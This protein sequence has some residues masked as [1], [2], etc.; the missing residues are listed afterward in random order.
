M[1][2]ALKGA[3]H[4]VREAVHDFVEDGCPT[5][6][7]SLSYYTVLSLPP[8]LVLVLLILG[9]VMDPEDVR[10]ALEEQI[11]T[12]MG[13][14]GADEVRKVIRNAERPGAGRPLASLLGIGA[15][16]FGAT[17]AFAQ[18]QAALNRAWEVEPDPAQGGIRNFVRKRLLSFG[19]ILA[20]GF[21]LLV[22]L[23]LSAALSAVG[24]LVAGRMAG[25]SGT[26]LQLMNSV[27]SFLV[28]TLLFAAIYKILPDARIAWR[29][30]WVGAA[31]TTLLF[32]LGKYFLGLYLGR[33]SPGDAYGAAGSLAVL[34]VWI[35]YS[36]MILLFGAELT[37]RWAE[38]HGTAIVPEKGAVRVVEVKRRVRE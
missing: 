27:V 3:F 5:M 2:S 22:S 32:V 19:M 38:S 14:V 33:S 12:V 20:I 7:A 34:L 30:T 4:L 35:Y 31:A 21:L 8:V 10:G 16:V 6:A 17:G 24:G 18:L 15:L 28:I 25:F 29:D 26:F 11:R 13:P 9:A 1:A 23:L 37:Q 36:S